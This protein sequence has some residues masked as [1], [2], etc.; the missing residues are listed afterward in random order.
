[1]FK[2]GYYKTKDGA[3]EARILRDGNQYGAMGTIKGIGFVGY[4]PTGICDN[5]EAHERGLDLDLETWQP[6][7]PVLK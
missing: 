5:E 6:L 4:G 3:H 7:K 1:M 2:A